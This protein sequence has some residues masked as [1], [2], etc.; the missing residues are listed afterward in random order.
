M[1][2]KLMLRI[3]QTLFVLCF[4]EQTLKQI[5][6]ENILRRLVDYLIKSLDLKVMDVVIA[7]IKMFTFFSDDQLAWS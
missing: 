4:R 3:I 7:I 2:W 1:N 5:K 6:H